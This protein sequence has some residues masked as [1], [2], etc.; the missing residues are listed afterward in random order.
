[1]KKKI[2]LTLLFLTT[3]TF[4][5]SPSFSAEKETAKKQQFVVYYVDMQRVINESLKGK[6]AKKLIEAK[7]QNA[8]KKIDEMRKEI[9]K[10]KQDLQNPVISK[11]EKDK[12]E[13]LL[14]QKIRDLQRFQQ[15][16]Q[17][18]V[19]RLERKYTSE[20]LKEIV[21]LIQDYQKKEKLPMIVDVREA[22]IIAADPKYDLTDKIIKLYD[23]QAEK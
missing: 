17:L 7:I 4:T 2:F 11:Q 20:L 1:M 19:M 22:G 8:K 9:N 12:K 15:D 13:D 23:Q 10:I 5:Y 21:K 18:E 14:Q 16:T 3:S 6:Q